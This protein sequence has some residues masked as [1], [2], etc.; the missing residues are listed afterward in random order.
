MRVSYFAYGSNMNPDKL[1]NR[2]VFFYSMRPATLQG[3]RLVFNKQSSKFPTVGFANVIEDEN[4][5]V[6][7]IIYE[8]NDNDIQNLDYFE[9]FPLNYRR[10]ILKVE[11]FGG[12]EED[13]I[14][15][16]A[17]PEKVKEGL[18][19]TEKY[20]SNFMNARK[21]LTKEYF[22]KLMKIYNENQR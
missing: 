3:Y 21:Y 15:Y 13:A 7:G 2:G 11:S 8:I 1:R 5:N 22:N 4:S 6:E 20:F 18:R 10:E 19:I 17:Q 16:I 9:G 12:W 14:V